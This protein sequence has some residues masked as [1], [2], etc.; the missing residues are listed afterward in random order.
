M[1]IDVYDNEK[2]QQPA[3]IK[4]SKIN[5]EQ[6]EFKISDVFLIIFTIYNYLLSL[7]HYVYILLV[8]ELYVNSK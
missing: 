4:L 3:F 2:K 1:L 6:H 5:F 8:Q 7:V